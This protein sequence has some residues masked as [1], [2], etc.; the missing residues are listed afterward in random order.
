MKSIVELFVDGLWQL[1]AI[2]Y[3]KQESADGNYYY[4]K[5]L[6][7]PA[8]GWLR[9]LDATGSTNGLDWLPFIFWKVRKG[10]TGK[11]TRGEVD[12]YIAASPRQTN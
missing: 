11:A 12:A 9:Y 5:G 8:D 2:S 7:K 3:E 10:K 4:I 1:G 6:A